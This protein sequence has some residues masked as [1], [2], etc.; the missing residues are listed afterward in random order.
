MCEKYTG[1]EFREKLAKFLETVKGE[2][3][4]IAAAVYELIQ[5]TDNEEEAFQYFL[6]KGDDFESVETKEVSKIF[7]SSDIQ[8]LERNC[9][10]LI[11][12][13]LNKL[14]TKN[15]EQK[16]FYSELWKMIVRDNNLFESPDEKIYAFYKIWIDGRIPYYKLEDGLKM[17]NEAFKDIC[18]A[19]REEIK[20][21]IFILN[22]SFEQRTERCSLLIRILDTCQTEEEKSVVLAQILAMAERR[23]LAKVLDRLKD[24]EIG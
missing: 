20:K 6:E 14:I 1:N 7:T 19:K 11:D 3:I 17:E 9:N 15:M 24:S 8:I 18:E 10:T 16:I 23:S 2:K 22:S 13:V 4:D 12:G 21:A 5:R